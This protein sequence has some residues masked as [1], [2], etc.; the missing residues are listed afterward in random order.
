M[1]FFSI[2]STVNEYQYLWEPLC[3]FAFYCWVV[4]L[5]P[6]SLSFTG[7]IPPHIDG[8]WE[9][10]LSF[11]SHDCNRLLASPHSCKY[12]DVEDC[13]TKKSIKCAVSYHEA[14]LVPLSSSLLYICLSISAPEQHFSYSS[15]I[16]F[17]VYVFI[18]IS[19]LKAEINHLQVH[20]VC[21][22]R[23]S[24]GSFCSFMMYRLHLGSYLIS[25]SRWLFCNN[26][27]FV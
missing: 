10:S 4:V 22:V 15:L 5:Q 14:G 7:S 11:P 17:S 8:W 1:L 26:G 24:L 18:Y 21:I 12:V 25:N 20:T 23:C 9:R 3:S 16:S 27:D 19:S 2:Y 6:T 13:R